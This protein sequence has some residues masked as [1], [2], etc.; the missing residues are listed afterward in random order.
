MSMEQNRIYEILARALMSVCLKDFEEARIEAEMEDGR[1]S[2][3]Y[4]YR[5]HGT[6]EKG[7]SVGA[8]LDF[9]VDDAP[10]E[11]RQS[12]MQ[13]GRSAWRACTFKLIPDGS[14]SFDVVHRVEDQP[15]L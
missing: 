4:R 8:E 11:L 3:T 13:E 6:W 10:M 7:V 1:S 9:E 15:T 14:F 2:K 12:M 5:R